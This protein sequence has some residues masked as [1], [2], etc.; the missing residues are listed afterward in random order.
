MDPESRAEHDADALRPQEDAGTDTEAEQ[1]GTE[2]A[3]TV[4]AAPPG[5]VPDSPAEGGEPMP[6]VPGGPQ[7]DVP[8]AQGH[9]PPRDTEVAE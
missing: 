6:E 8:A 4:R 7:V 2:P 1:P 5:S 9:L 3:D